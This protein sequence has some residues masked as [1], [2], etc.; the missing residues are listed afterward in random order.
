[1][2]TEETGGSEGYE[3]LNTLYLSTTYWNA[4]VKEGKVSGTRSTHGA[5]DRYTFF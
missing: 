5:D 3:E 4:R 1:M 2:W